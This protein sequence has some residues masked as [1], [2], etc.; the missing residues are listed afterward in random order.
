MMSIGSLM[1]YLM[2]LILIAF[3]ETAAAV[4][5]VY[6]KLQS[7]FF[8]PVF[9]M[10]NGII[11]VL[12]YNYGA[13]KKKRIDE[14]LRFGLEL[15]VV[16]MICGTAILELFPT[17]LLKLFNASGDMMSMGKIALR[18]I[19]IHFPVAAIGISL[20]TVFQAFS[21]SYYSLIISLS[22]QLVVLIPVAWILAKVTNNVNMVWW[23]F[24]IAE[25]VSCILSIIFFKKVYKDVVEPLEETA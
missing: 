6:F 10:N 22:R 19:A 13:G 5:G 3:S 23:C 20:G 15:A 21:K 12:A 25:V 17:A 9:G 1:T 18:T 24:I 7:F 2:N 14:T 16:I 4:F 8:M 11:P